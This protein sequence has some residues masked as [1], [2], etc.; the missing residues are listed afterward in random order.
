MY[1]THRRQPRFDWFADSLARQLGAD[2]VEVVFVDGLRSRARTALL[3]EVVRDRF[4]FR[5]V[6]PKPTP[7]CGPQRLT[8]SDLFAVASARNTGIVHTKQ[9]YV[10][11][12]DDCALLAPGWLD[13]VREGAVEGRVTCGTYEKHSHLVAED[14]L[15]LSSDLTEAGLDSRR[16]LGDGTGPVPLGGGQLYGCSFGAPRDLLLAVNGLDELCDPMGGEDY[17][18][19]I[20]LE[21]A[22]AQIVYD[23]RMLTIE[24]GDADAHGDSPPR[25]G[26]SLSEDAYMAKL[27][28]F[29]VDARSTGGEFDNSHMVLDILYGT[30]SVQSV[31][32]DYSLGEL[33]V[34]D[35]PRLP[36][37]FP[38]DY[39]F[40]DLP[41]AELS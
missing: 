28:E 27:A 34:A 21:W 33:R 18:L 29:G 30:R 31:G 19:G 6:P 24:N 20:R 23:R 4:S 16:L 36:Y 10:V 26:R 15:H 38:L 40:D 12:V 17:Q 13:A 5:H 9:P 8:P 3:A 1:V 22:G 41:L 2:D 7:Y 25:I 32:N 37:Q 35:L 11:F 39:W 14:G